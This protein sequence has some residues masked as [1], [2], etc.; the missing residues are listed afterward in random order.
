MSNVVDVTVGARIAINSD[1]TAKV[2]SFG[3]LD[4]CVL[5]GRVDRVQLEYAIQV[6]LQG[7]PKRP[8]V[9]PT[10]QG[11]EDQQVSWPELLTFFGELAEA[12]EAFA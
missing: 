11:A 6:L 2:L 8:Y 5:Q 9:A 3:L 4:T 7:Q 10:L 1:G 12:Q